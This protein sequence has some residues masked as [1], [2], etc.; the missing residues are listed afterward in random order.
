MN[1]MTTVGGHRWMNNTYRAIKSQ[2]F[3][4]N[5]RREVE[6]Y[7]KKCRRCQVNKMLTPKHKAPRYC[8]PLTCDT[9]SHKYIITFKDDLSKYV[10]A[11]PLGQQD[12]E[13]VARAFVVNIVLNTARLVFYKLIR[14]L[15]SLVRCSETPARCLRLRNFNLLRFTPNRKGVL[16]GAIVC[17]LTT[18]D[19]M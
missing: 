16:R 14:A 15:T 5:V 13:T 7:V 6:E 4:L 9:R 3:W 2:N 1:F 17:W 10:V 11:V 12:A 8:G 18:S 19:I